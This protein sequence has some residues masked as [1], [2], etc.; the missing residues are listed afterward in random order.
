M[1]AGTN[2]FVT[3][4][5]TTTG[6]MYLIR[7]AEGGSGARSN[8]SWLDGGAARRGSAGRGDGVAV[9]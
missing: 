9:S 2:V 1:S 8:R 6:L 4:G 7:V 3:N 5:S